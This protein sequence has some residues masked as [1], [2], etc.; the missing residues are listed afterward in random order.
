MDRGRPGG[1]CKWRV[2]GGCNSV[3]TV[4]K[5]GGLNCRPPV[6]PLKLVPKRRLELPR[7]CPHMNLNHPSPPDFSLESTT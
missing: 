4:K 5:N 1:V 3:V 7:G 6:N 2:V